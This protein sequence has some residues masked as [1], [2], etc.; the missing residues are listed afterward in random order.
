MGEEQA[1]Q[2]LKAGWQQNWGQAGE[3][4]SKG[5]SWPIQVM[6]SK[7]AE[8]ETRL[9]DGLFSKKAKEQPEKSVDV[10]IWDEYRAAGATVPEP[11]A[12]VLF[13][14]GGMAVLRRRYWA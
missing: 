1:Y 2:K 9:L 12:L 5:M 13:A 6:S 3:I 8:K 10:E 4:L 14:L 7:Y 11:A